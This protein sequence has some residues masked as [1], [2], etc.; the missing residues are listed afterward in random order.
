MLLTLLKII[1]GI[2]VLGI[3]ALVMIAVV[4]GLISSVR[5]LGKREKHDGEPRGD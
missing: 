1:A 2:A 3:I 4:S 5:S